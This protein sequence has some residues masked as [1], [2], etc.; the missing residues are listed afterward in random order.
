MQTPK[1]YDFVI[2]FDPNQQMNKKTSAS[3]RY[4]PVTIEMDIYM[5]D[6]KPILSLMNYKYKY[7]ESPLIVLK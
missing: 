6:Y 1:K 4:G 7:S 3:C 5:A 2:V